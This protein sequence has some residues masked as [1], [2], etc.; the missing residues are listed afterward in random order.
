MYK[1]VGHRRSFPEKLIEQ[2]DGT[3]IELAP[4]CTYTRE[5]WPPR[6]R[7]RAESLTSPRRIAAKVRALQAV[8][9]RFAGHTWLSIAQTLGFADASGAWRACRRLCDYADWNRQKKGV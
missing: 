4:G 1:A 8:R 2:P 5:T 6:G 9:L 3:L 7:G